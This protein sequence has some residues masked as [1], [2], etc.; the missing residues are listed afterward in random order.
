MVDVIGWRLDDVVNKIRGKK[1]TTVR[2]EV[3]PAD[4]GVDGKHELVTIV[5][6]K[7]VVEEQ[8]AKSKV[9]DIKDGDVTRKIGVI[10]LPTFY[11]DFAARSKGDPNY[12]SATRDVAKLLTKLKADGVQGVIMDLRNNG[13]GSLDE[14]NELTGLFIDKGPVVQVRKAN[15][16]VDV[17][18]DDDAGLAWSG[19]MAVLVNRGSASAS[20]IFAAAIQDHGR[21]LII[22][23]PT[24]GK[25]TVQNLVD[26]DRFAADA[27]DERE[28]ADGR[29]EDDH[30][31]VLPHQRRLH[32]AQGRHAGHPVPEERRREGF[33]R[34]HL[35]QCAAVDADRPGRLQA[36]GRS[37]GLPAAV[38]ADARRARG[39]VAGVEAAARPAG[40]VP[41]DARPDQHLAQPGHAPGRAQAS[42]MRCR[43]ISAPAARRSTATTAVPADEDSGSTMA[44]TPTSAA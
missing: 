33:R 15:G 40:A 27:G 44:S 39:Q 17:Q 7:V 29:A 6:N 34:V 10:D 9:I 25:G 30:R 20:E 14:A 42:R 16:E 32:P 35:R 38:A 8:A 28:A 18:G 2:L 11:A 37:Q 4:T 13:G 22:G 1:G 12:K 43:P 3:L 21:G 36:G 31:G 23:E 19:P 41:Q 5:R 24:F 26:L